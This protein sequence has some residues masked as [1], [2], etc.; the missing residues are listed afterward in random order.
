MPL[1]SLRPPRPRPPPGPADT[2]THREASRF[3]IEMDQR[4]ICHGLEADCRIGEL[5]R[6]K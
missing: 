4:G 3:V 6:V 1:L 2:S 5:G